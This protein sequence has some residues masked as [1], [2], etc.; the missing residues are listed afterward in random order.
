MKRIAPILVVV[1][2]L[3]L[4][5]GLAL[6]QSDATQPAQPQPAQQPAQQPATPTDQ[7]TQSTTPA[8][9]TSIRATNAC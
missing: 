8:Q 4:L 1:F 3:A 9:S 5:A 2:G 7:A 6:A